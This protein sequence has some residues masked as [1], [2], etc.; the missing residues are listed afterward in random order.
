[1]IHHL[2]SHFLKEVFYRDLS[3]LTEKK[4]VINSFVRLKIFFP[5]KFGVSN[6]TAKIARLIFLETCFPF[7]Q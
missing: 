4:V 7:F 6:L 5:R 3:Q 2:C 1:M